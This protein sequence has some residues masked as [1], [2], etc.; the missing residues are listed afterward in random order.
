VA[1]IL[2]KIVQNK[3]KELEKRKKALPLE[4]MLNALVTATP[5]RP[6]RAA[7]QRPAGL[8]LIA[9]IK[10]ASPSKGVLVKN[11]DPKKLA[12]TY[13]AHGAS[14]ISV[15]TDEK[16]F[17]GKLEFIAE[18]KKAC[19]LPVLRKDFIIDPYQVY[20]SRYFRADA[21]LILAALYPK[22][23]DLKKVCQLVTNLSMTPLV[24]V[25][26]RSELARALKAEAEVIGVNNRD[27][28]TFKVDLKTSFQLAK[29]V[30]KTKLLVAESGIRGVKE[31]LQL[32]K[33]GFKAILVG[34]ALL[35]DRSN[36]PLAREL[37]AVGQDAY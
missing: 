20:E 35:K 25:H 9:E 1:T 21:V 14:A 3:K 11:L 7:L 12:E 36:P 19:S 10:K 30:P 28:N 8:A 6:F 22:P 18:A 17:Q 27:L 33:A 29:K 37:S 13:A 16:F 32:W 34:E 5:S 23:R 26:T 2:R 24:E 15:V 31:A 4:T